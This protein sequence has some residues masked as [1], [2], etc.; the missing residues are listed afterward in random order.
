MYIRPQYF[1][2]RILRTVNGV[3]KAVY[4]VDLSAITHALRQRIFLRLAEDSTISSHKRAIF[5][6]AQQKRA[7]GV[8][9]EGRTQHNT[10]CENLDLAKRFKAEL[11]KINRSFGDMYKAANIH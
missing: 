8:C 9:V 1:K 10:M 4:I 3:C 11:R 5:C 2:Y 6:V 7:P